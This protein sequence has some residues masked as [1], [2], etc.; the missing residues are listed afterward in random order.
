MAELWL[1]GRFKIGAMSLGRAPLP[2]PLPAA[3]G[4][5]KR[6]QGSARDLRVA[7]RSWNESRYGQSALSAF[8]SRWLDA[9]SLAARAMM[10][11]WSRRR[12]VGRWVKKS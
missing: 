9:H 12:M 6:L 8:R 11:A 1:T 2:D 3:R 4:E 7:P 5:G 10:T